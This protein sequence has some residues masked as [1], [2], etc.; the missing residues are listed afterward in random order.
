MQG[1]DDLP[2]RPTR[3]HQIARTRLDD[4][5]KDMVGLIG[6]ELRY[7]FSVVNVPSDLDGAQRLL[8][9]MERKRKDRN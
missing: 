5:R 3:W 8:E 6:R 2:S 1:S 7:V 4:P 9:E